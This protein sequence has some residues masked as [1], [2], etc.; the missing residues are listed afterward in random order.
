MSNTMEDMNKKRKYFSE[1]VSAITLTSFKLKFDN[2]FQEN[3]G[4][5]S[6]CSKPP[7]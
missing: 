4:E 7:F 3:D 5:T 1:A 2:L 6:F